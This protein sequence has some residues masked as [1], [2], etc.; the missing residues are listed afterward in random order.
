MSPETL[1]V[2][3]VNTCELFAPVIAIQPDDEAPKCIWHVGCVVPMPTFVVV[4]SCVPVSVI[5]PLPPTNHCCCVP[6]GTEYHI[7]PELMPMENG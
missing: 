1:E 2:A 3:P 7:V 5:T 6:A 4:V